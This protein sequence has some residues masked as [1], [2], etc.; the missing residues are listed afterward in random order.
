MIV[1]G[2]ATLLLVWFDFMRAREAAVRAARG[3][4]RRLD[5]QLLDQTVHLGKVALGRHA[6]RPALCRIYAFE[7][8]VT[9]HE[10]QTG[11]VALAGRHI[12][13]VDQVPVESH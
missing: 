2:A 3:F 10:R 7:F 6:G 9:G 12:V 5:V 1:I 8:T 4:C 11:Y 13:E